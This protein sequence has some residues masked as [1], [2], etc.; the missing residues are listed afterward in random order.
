M[1]NTVLMEQS[2]DGRRNRSYPE[3]E[4]CAAKGASVMYLAV[5]WR[6]AG[7]ARRVHPDPVRAAPRGPAGRVEGC[8][9]AGMATGDGQTT[10]K[11]VG[12][13][14]GIDEVHGE[15]KPAGQAQAC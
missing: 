3:A 12:A 11:A 13:R 14:L 1:G 7:F 9:P 6:L 10:A 15:V 8:G 4:A 2:G 5:D